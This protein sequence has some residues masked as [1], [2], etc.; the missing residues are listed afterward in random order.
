[1]YMS[2]NTH[3]QDMLVRPITDACKLS[4]KMAFQFMDTDWMNG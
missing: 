4:K 3:T 2:C 1:M